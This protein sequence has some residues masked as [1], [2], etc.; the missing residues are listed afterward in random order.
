M[1]KLKSIGALLAVSLAVVACEMK[2]PENNERAVLPGEGEQCAPGFIQ[3]PPVYPPC[4]AGLE[5]AGC[6][7]DTGGFCCPPG[8]RPCGTQPHRCV[9]AGS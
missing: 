3:N 2:A 5:C 8:L 9:D 4:G 7:P 6:I 1:L